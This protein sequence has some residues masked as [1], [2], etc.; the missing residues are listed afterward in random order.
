[1]RLVHVIVAFLV[2]SFD[3]AFALSCS[4]QGVN[5]VSVRVLNSKN[6]KAVKGVPI[7]LLSLLPNT[8][9][10]PYMAYATI[11]IGKT[12]KHGIA[13][14]CIPGPIPKSFRLEFYEFSGPDK[15]EAFDAETVL[16]HG[17]VA[18][19][20]LHGKKSKLTPS[21]KP[22]EVVVFGQRWWLIDRWLGPWP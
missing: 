9:E 5:C 16:K 7:N 11:N 4:A 20:A 1:M 8:S 22:G 19:H 12:D 15:R 3:S 18:I 2:L 21:P 17:V 10:K 13:K 6:G 14:Y